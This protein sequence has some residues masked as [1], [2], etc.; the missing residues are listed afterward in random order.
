MPTIYSPHDRCELKSI[1]MASKAQIDRL[2]DRLQSGNISEDDLRMLDEY[3]RSFSEAYEHVVDAIRY[4][5]GFEV[6]GR[7]AKS[8]TSISEKLQ[9]ETIRLTQIQDI[10]GCRLIVLD[11]AQQEQANLSMLGL[12]SKATLVDRRKNPSHGYRAIHVIVRDAD[13]L[14]EVQVR[15]KLQHLWAEQSEKLSDVVHPGIKYGTGD[16]RLVRVLLKTS[17][18]IAEEEDRETELVRLQ[19]EVSDLLSEGKL[20][21][22]VETR[23]ISLQKQVEEAQQRQAERRERGLEILQDGIDLVTRE[24]K[25]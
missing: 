23:L 10:A 6:T 3:R 4:R 13:K 11:I 25:K 17:G 14:V 8:T 16:E 20:E 9:R 19:T 12:F 5:L 24:G 1:R 22:G 7:P 2:G 18:I 15:T 21:P